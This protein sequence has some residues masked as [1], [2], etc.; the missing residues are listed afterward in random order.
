[1]EIKSDCVVKPFNNRCVTVVAQRY[2]TNI[3]TIGHNQFHRTTQCFACSKIWPQNVSICAATLKAPNCVDTF[4]R[5]NRID[6]ELTLV[7]IRATRQNDFKLKLVTNIAVSIILS[8][9]YLFEFKTNPVRQAHA[10]LPS[11][12]I[13]HSC[14]HFEFFSHFF[15]YKM[16][17]KNHLTNLEKCNASRIY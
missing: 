10:S 12:V 1:M 11:C 9:L 6:C 17:K 4:L 13:T 5:T 2:L 7:Y 14:S 8:Y 15:A 16:E 3:D